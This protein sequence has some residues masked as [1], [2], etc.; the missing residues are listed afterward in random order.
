MWE[1]GVCEGFGVDVLL[2]REQQHDVVGR[3]GRAVGSL[4]AIVASL[5]LFLPASASWGDCFVCA[6]SSIG[7]SMIPSLPTYVKLNFLVE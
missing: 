2:V 1:R 7:S 5:C 6:A 3:R 4:A